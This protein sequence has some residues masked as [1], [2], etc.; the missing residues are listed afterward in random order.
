MLVSS[1]ELLVVHQNLRGWNK[2][3]SAIDDVEIRKSS[4][5]RLG[6]SMSTQSP[7]ALARL[8]LVASAWL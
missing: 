8:L 6:K 5:S 2:G 7:N 3:I 1:D 4:L